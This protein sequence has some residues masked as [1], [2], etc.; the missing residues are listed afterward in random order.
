MDVR[1]MPRRLSLAVALIA[2]GAAGLAL[3]PAASAHQNSLRLG[4]ITHIGLNDLGSSSQANGATTYTS[5][6]WSGY[7]INGGTN[8]SVSTTW[9]QPEVRCTTTPN[10]Y[11]A[12]WAGLDGFSSSTVE[13]DGTLAECVGTRPEYLGWYETYPNPMYRFGGAVHPG[14]TLTSTVTAVST[15]QFVLTLADTPKT[16]TPWRVSTT[17]TLTSP[18]ALSSAE[19]IAEAPSSSSGVLPLADFGL[20]N[21]TSSS[22]NG[23]TLVNGPNTAEI[24]MVSSR[25]VV[26]AVPGALTSTGGF[27][28]QW[29]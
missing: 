22:V 23:A 28:V 21:F 10:S 3:V 5:T 1:K 15:T 9:I 17:Q 24:E 18:A 11:A 14:D 4:G 29:H 26:E 20:M 19:V 12:F 6:N 8:H 27:S 16:G 7:A 25:G 13:Q 2:S